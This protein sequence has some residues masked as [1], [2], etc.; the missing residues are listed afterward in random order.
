[1]GKKKLEE[2]AKQR[3]SFVKGCAK[4]NNIPA[5]KANQV[6]DLLEKFAGYGFNK[7]HAA[8]YAI[9]AYQTAYL[10]ANYPVE[11]LSAMLT[12]DMGDTAKMSILIHEARSFGVEI[13]PPDVNESQVAF[14]PA[15]GG[16]VIRFGLAAVKGIGEV[17]VE[18]ILK[19]REEGGKF[20][21]LSDLCQ[22]VDGRTVNRKVLEAL[23]KSGACD[24]FGETRA[25]L[26]AQ[27]DYTLARAASI[28]LDRQRGQASLFGTLEEHA[29]AAPADV[30]EKLPEWPQSELLAAEKEL[31]GFY[32]TGH[33]LTPFAD[34]LEKYSLTNATAAAQVQKFT[35]TRLGGMI[36]AVQQGISKKS[37]KPYALVTLEDLAGTIQVL[38]MNENYDKFRELLVPNKAVLVV[39]EVNNADDKPKIFPQEIM[40]LE[41]APRR[42]T[43]QVH[44][45][46]NTAH[47]NSGRLE[48]LR[49]L[50]QAHPGKCP[51]FLC[52]RQPTGEAIFIETHERYSIAP[53]LQFQQATD[54]LFGEDTYYAKVDVSL[55]E[56]APRRWERKAEPGAEDG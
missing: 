24:T 5:A 1:M 52:L 38:C 35:L 6:F 23:I 3:D 53:S 29:S 48:S 16:T 25:T 56:R 37:G 44:L 27:I 49:D 41:D 51:L 15:R 28:A 20:T 34:I 40:P 21:S 30:I 33:P 14:A 43:K 12:N 19:A 46:L 26:F 11:F 17:A 13:L 2:M 4:V 31:L 36:T 8:A 55:P 9:V 18:S 50:V 22:R 10:K 47:L 7:S 54:E 42:Y 45:R 32:V 39:G